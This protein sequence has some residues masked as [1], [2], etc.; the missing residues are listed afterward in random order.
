MNI[1]R[2]KSFSQKRNLIPV[3]DFLSKDE[4]EVLTG[5]KP[6]LKQ[7]LNRILNRFLNGI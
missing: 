7:V 5:S 3:R 6:D 4:K 1:F 2:R